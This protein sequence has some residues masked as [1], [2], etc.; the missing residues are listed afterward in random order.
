M[1]DTYDRIRYAL[2]RLAD[3][4]SWNTTQLAQAI[5]ED[6]PIEFRFRRG[7]TDHYMSVSSI[8]R[9]L[10]LAV[11][12][13]LAERVTNERNT[14]KLTDRGAKCL[15]SEKQCA[16][17]VRACVTTFLDNNNVGLDRVKD[18]VSAIRLPNVPDAKTIFIELSAD[19]RM[20]MGE[21]L[22]RTMMY[23]LWRAG[24]AERAVKVL[25]KI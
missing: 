14:I 11:D 1:A 7:Q 3:K 13:D 2:G 23:L 24:G 21:K 18:A 9:I 15:R 8:R 17:Q 16:L 12:L 20:T 4:D 22:F 25:Y 10:R 19:P 6:A 5:Q